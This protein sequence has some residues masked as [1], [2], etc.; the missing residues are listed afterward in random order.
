MYP[1]ESG[2]VSLHFSSSN[3]VD[4]VAWL[5]PRN[6]LLRRRCLVP[7]D[8]FH[9]WQRTGK[10]KE[11][12]CFEMIGREPFAFAGLW[13]RWR[14]PDGA[15]L[16]SCTILTTKPNRLLADVH[17]RMPVILPPESLID[18]VDRT[19]RVIHKNCVGARL[20]GNFFQRVE[21]IGRESRPGC[22]RKP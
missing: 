9:E 7:A 19:R 13:D 10:S 22:A 21:V 11:P 4:V 20:A 8:A 3:P 5:S 14:A 17:N 18:F 6:P 12:Y 16:Y 1:R 2:E 15:T